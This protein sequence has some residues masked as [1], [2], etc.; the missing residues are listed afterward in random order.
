MEEATGIRDK[1]FM[2]VSIAIKVCG[3]LELRSWKF[4][5][6]GKRASRIWDFLTCPKFWPVTKQSSW[7]YKIERLSI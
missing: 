3:D 6:L 4:Q 7:I 2:T 5:S 1:S